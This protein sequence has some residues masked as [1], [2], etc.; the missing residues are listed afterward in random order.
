M[1]VR[2]TSC[3]KN[4]SVFQ[5]WLDIFFKHSYLKLKSF[6]TQNL[7][8]MSD[9]SPVLKANQIVTYDIIII[10]LGLINIT[11]VSIDIH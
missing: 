9:F 5:N 11:D 3:D 4:K 2:K 10:T 8:F 1:T 6:D 7:D